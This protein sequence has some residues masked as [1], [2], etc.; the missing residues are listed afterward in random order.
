VTIVGN[1]AAGAGGGLRNS[2]SSPQ[3]RNSIVWGNRVGTTVSAINDT[4]STPAASY[5]IIEGGYSGTSNLSSAPQFVNPIDAASAPT[6]SGDYHLQANSPALNTGN[7]AALPADSFDLD[8]DSNIT[9]P[10]PYD[11]SGNAR[12]ANG[13]VDMG[14]YER[15]ANLPPTLDQLPDLT[16]LEDAGA[17]MVSL[18]GIGSGGGSQ[19]LS[20]TAVSANSALIPN[21]SVSYSSPDSSGSLSFTPVANA[22]GTATITVTVQDSGGTANGGSD[23]LVRTFTIQVTPVNDAPSFTA[24]PNKTVPSSA[25]PQTVTGWASG[26]SA[27][28]ADE[29]SQTLL[30]YTIV[31]NSA[32]ELFAIAPTVDASG[33]LTYTPK[34]SAH[35]TATI[36]VVARD[37]GGTAN[38]GIDTSAV[39][40]FTIAIGASYQ[41]YLPLVRVP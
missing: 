41:I 31:S 15:Q 26:F 32:P 1:R 12:V 36:S 18:T 7:N 16:T 33:S 10:I 19:T 38:G 35:G 21:P 30:G 5:S 25:G 3:I 40:T 34:P 4:N 28:P 20:I 23:T 29:A 13:T 27:G 2:S 8:G 37:S 6:S 39:H 17:Q 24:G 14:A 22:N 9:E 11:S